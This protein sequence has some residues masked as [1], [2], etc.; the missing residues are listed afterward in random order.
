MESNLKFDIIPFGNIVKLKSGFAFKSESWQNKGIPVIKIANISEELNMNDCSY[1]SENNINYAREFTAYEGDI[2]IAMTG[3][4][5]GKFCLIPP[6]NGTILI[7]QRVGKLFPVSSHKML[8]ILPYIYCMLSN[9][10]IINELINLGSG[11]AQPNISGNDFNN[12]HIKYN[13]NFFTKFNKKYNIVFKY[14]LENIYIIE[15]LNHL[16]QLYLKKFFG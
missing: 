4:T 5:L 3:A 6:H 2:I 13:E 12:I 16:K 1:V 10:E 15:K 8:N 11:S 9:P 7:N 14:I